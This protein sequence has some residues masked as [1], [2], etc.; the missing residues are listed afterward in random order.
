MTQP[1]IEP[2]HTKSLSKTTKKLYSISN[3]KK[4][5]IGEIKNTTSKENRKHILRKRKG[6][7][8]KK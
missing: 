3:T 6:G 4:K 7:K 5:L 1:G 8:K 2:R